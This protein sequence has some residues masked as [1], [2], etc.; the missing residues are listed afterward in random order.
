LAS[1]TTA[2]QSTVVELDRDAILRRMAAALA[3][4]GRLLI[5]DFD[6]DSA[7]P[8]PDADAGETYLTTHRALARLMSDRGFDRRYGRRLFRRFQ[9]YGLTE[10]AAEGRM[11]MCPG[12]SPGTRL[13]RANVEQLRDAL[14]D[15]GDVTA[16]VFDDDLAALSRPD[17][18]M[19]SSILW[20][21]RGRCVPR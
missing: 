4:G 3:P 14:I 9:E 7:P 6:S 18:V 2:L 10:V 12:G 11:F 1:L 8:E 21:V 17:F 5:E 16:Q 20:S 15:G 19:P 13:I